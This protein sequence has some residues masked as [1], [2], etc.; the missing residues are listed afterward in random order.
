MCFSTVSKRQNFHLLY[1]RDIGLWAFVPNFISSFTSRTKGFWKNVTNI[2]N[3]MNW[4]ILCSTFGF[5][6]F[7]HEFA[8]SVDF[9]ELAHNEPPHLDLYYLPCWLWLLYDI[10]WT[11]HFFLAH[12][13]TKCSWWAIVISQ[14]P[15]CV[16]CRASSTIC[17]KS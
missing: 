8:N 3:F 9:D 7:C 12:L 4:L 16:V 2:Q 10:A 5:C 6:V 11:K 17:F 13:S 1:G 14:C 15:S